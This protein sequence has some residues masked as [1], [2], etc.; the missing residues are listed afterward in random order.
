MIMNKTEVQRY[1]KHD[2]VIHRWLDRNAERSIKVRGYTIRPLP[3]KLTDREL[4]M[5]APQSSFQWFQATGP[6]IINEEKN[7]FAM[8]MRRQSFPH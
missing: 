3:W 1:S 6:I 4:C 5:S 7:K 8:S 2:T